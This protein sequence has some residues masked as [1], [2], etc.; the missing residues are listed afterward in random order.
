MLVVEDDALLRQLTTR[1]L[2][3]FG[4]IVDSAEDGESG[5]DALNAAH[6]DLLVTD[7]EMPRLS[8]MQ[9]VE[10]LRVSD[11]SIP[12][13]MVSGA[14]G[15]G[16]AEDHPEL[17]LSVILHKPFVAAA[18]IAAARGVLGA[19][20]PFPPNSHAN[21][22]ENSSSP[23]NQTEPM[24][25]STVKP[26]TESSGREQNAETTSTDTGRAP[27]G[28]KCIL[29]VDDDE[30]VRSSLAAV[31]E[32]EGY[33]VRS[34]DDG[35]SAIR[36]AMDHQPSLVLL[37]LNMA[38]MDGWT[39]FTHLESVRPLLPVIVLTARPDQYRNAVKLGV[40]AFMEKPLNFPILLGAIRKLADETEDQHTKRIISHG[41][42]T[43][44]LDN[45]AMACS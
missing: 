13:I 43:K 45:H 2:A 35:E 29:V 36:I 21:H 4:Y 1:I 26:Q 40:D 3:Q 8:G 16:E 31:L 38:K 11:R 20:N 19:S 41:F 22:P 18:L 32:C 23:C 7:N 34:A 42:V 14:V 6:Y 25:T 15:I 12:A 37:D 24:K 28:P 9:L 44:R 5:W 10:R 17:A 33:L 27:R 30:V 39:T